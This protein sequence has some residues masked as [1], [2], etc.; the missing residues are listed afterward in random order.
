LYCD[1]DGLDPILSQIVTVPAG[2]IADA[3]A[4]DV[5]LPDA[6]SLIELACSHTGREVSADTLLYRVQFHYLTHA[7]EKPR[8]SL[9]TGYEL[10]ELGQSYLDS[11]AD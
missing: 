4:Q 2:E 6:E 9:E 7:P 11:I 3:D 8:L 5:V 1:N 10:S